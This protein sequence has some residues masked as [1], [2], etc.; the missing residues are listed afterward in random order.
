MG[1]NNS[2]SLTVKDF[3]LDKKVIER[4]SLEPETHINTTFRIELINQ[5]KDNPEMNALFRG[6]FTAQY[7][8]EIESQDPEILLNISM[9]I[10][11]ATFID[12]IEQ[13]NLENPSQEHIDIGLNAMY[14]IARSMIASELSYLKRDYSDIPYEISGS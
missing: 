10:Q 2:V 12:G 11:F 4:N 9:E 7:V 1:S 5:F 6:F 13:V 14:P 3:L 8:K